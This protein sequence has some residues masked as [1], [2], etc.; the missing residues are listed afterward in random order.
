MPTLLP[1]FPRGWAH[2][3][4]GGAL[5]GAGVSLIYVSTGAAAGTSSFF[6]AS[7][8]WASGLPFFRQARWREERVWRLLYA[9]G[10]I[11]G[12][13]LWRLETGTSL[14]TSV[15]PW[16]LL[17]GGL[18]AGFGTRLSGGCTAGHGICGIASLKRESFVAVPV[19]LLT[20]VLVA[21]LL[22]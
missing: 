13:L 18:L 16:R 4:G 14:A 22:P 9:A 21:H 7:W 20:A 2:Y 3:L 8:S 5:I 11:A 17:V 19:F 12:A 6:S 10:L 15:A 1:L